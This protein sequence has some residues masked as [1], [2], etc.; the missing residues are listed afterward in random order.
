MTI[1]K[2]NKQFADRLGR[3]SFAAD[4]ARRLQRD[5]HRNWRTHPHDA[6][7]EARLQFCVI[8]F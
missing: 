2:I 8:A 3:T 5:F 4:S 7:D 6:D 1:T